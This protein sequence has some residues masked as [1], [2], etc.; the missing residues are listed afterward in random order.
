MSPTAFVEREFNTLESVPLIPYSN[1]GQSSSF[2]LLDTNPTL[3]SLALKLNIIADSDPESP[4]SQYISSI[5]NSPRDSLALEHYSNGNIKTPLF[6]SILPSGFFNLQEYNDMSGIYHFTS[7]DGDDYVGSST[8]LKKR[9]NTHR[10][11]G[12]NSNLTFKHKLF[13]NEVIKHG[14]EIFNLN[15]LTTFK[16]YSSIFTELHPDFTSS[17]LNNEA[18]AAL[19]RYQITLVEQSFIDTLEPKLNSAPFANASI[20]NLGA[21]GVI[22]DDSFKTAVSLAH[23]GREYAESTLKL[24]R[25][26]NIGRVASDETKELM[27]INNKGVKIVVTDNL[28]GIS[29]LYNTKSEAALALGISLRTVTRWGNEPNRIRVLKS[30]RKV[31]VRIP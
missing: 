2:L 14:W 20:Y 21:T 19:D 6:S 4:L 24:H 27:A 25:E 15:I 18:L 29:T 8:G 22:R 7:A 28:T 16:P 17:D 9:L 30:G 12:L 23:Q 1:L 5:V 26:K 3:N 10:I 13:Y 11:Q 31:S